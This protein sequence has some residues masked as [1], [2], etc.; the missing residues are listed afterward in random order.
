GANPVPAHDYTDPFG[1]TIQ[2]GTIFDPNSTQLNVP[3][4]TA[5]SID[6]GANGT[7]R[8]VRNPYVGNKVPLTQQDKVA[9]AIQSKYIPLPQGPNFTAG[10]LGSNYFNPFLTRRITRSP[11]VKIDQNLTSTAR[12]SFSWTDNHTESPYQSLG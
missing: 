10:I 4:N 8:T 9:L 11:A 2:A 1:R 6:C 7:L 12:L 3:C 5:V